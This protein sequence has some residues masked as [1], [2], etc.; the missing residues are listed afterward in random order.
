MPEEQSKS[1]MTRDELVELVGRI[2]RLEA[3]GTVLDGW[4]QQLIRSVPHPRVCDMIF[5]PD[6]E[7]T[8]EE[9]VDEA[10]AFKSEKTSR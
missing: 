5:W 8:A 1:E 9:I 2:M 4:V 6:K 10:L 7:R 3:K